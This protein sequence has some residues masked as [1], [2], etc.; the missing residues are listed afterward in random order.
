MKVRD[1]IEGDQG[2]DVW[3]AGIEEIEG[4]TERN[5]HAEALLAKAKLL[6]ARREMAVIA[7]IQKIQDVEGEMPEELQRYKNAIGKRLNAAAKGKVPADLLDRFARA[8]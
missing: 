4:L 5:Q 6:R 7:L 1:L 2:R 8:A 3:L